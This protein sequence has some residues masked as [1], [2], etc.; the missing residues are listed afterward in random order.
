M[1]TI[2]VLVPVWWP[3]GG[4]RTYLKYVLSNP[5]FSNYHFTF[6]SS[7]AMWGNFSEELEQINHTFIGTAD[8]LFHFYHAIRRELR[9]KQFAF[10]HAHGLTSA[11][12]AVFAL[13]FRKPSLV[14]TLHDIFNIWQMESRLWPLKKFMITCFLNKVNIIHCVGTEAA[15]NM[16]DSLPGLR[17]RTITIP[18]GIRTRQFLSA[19]P[20]D[21]NRL[22][23]LDKNT[24]LIGFLGRFMSQKGF[25]Y[26][27][28]AVELLSN[29]AKQV[30]SVICFGDGGFIREDQQYIDEMHLNKYFH[31]MPPVS[32]IAP[33]LKSLDVIAIPSLWEACPLLPMEALVA[34]TPVIGTNCTGLKEV[35]LGTP[36]LIIEPHNAEMLKDAILKCMG[37]NLRP[38]FKHYSAIASERFDITGTSLSMEKFYRNFSEGHQHI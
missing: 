20:I 1:K 27:I 19:E 36:A 37:S 14:V 6:V 23:N 22:L 4:I 18:N 2:C 15:N 16:H 24:F 17:T 25:R 7:E 38:E 28:K 35:L 5:V 30:F 11:V 31:F 12:I 32:N 21:L 34:G 33:I 26:L 3:V 8:N 13:L 10:I 9:G 29:E